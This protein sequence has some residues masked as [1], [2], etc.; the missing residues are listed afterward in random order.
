MAADQVRSGPAAGLARAT[1][2]LARATDGLARA[3]AGRGVLPV[4]GLLYLLAIVPVLAVDIV[5]LADFTNHIARI[6][7]LANIA[8]DPVLQSNY[9]LDWAI[10]PNLGIDILLP[11]LTR[12]LP[13]FVVG[14][15]FVAATLLSL[16]GGV[17]A[18]HRVLHGKVGLWPAAAFLFLYNMTLTMGFLNFL[19]GLGL[20]L[21]ALAGWIALRGRPAWWRIALFSAVAVVLFFTHLMALGAYGLL[22]GAWELSFALNPPRDWRRAVTDWSIGGAQFVA[23][24]LLLLVSL[25]PAPA[26]T[27]VQYASPLAKLFV[28]LAPVLSYQDMIDGILFLF[29][30]IV[31]AF[32]LLTRRFAVAANMG[33]PMLLLGAAAAFLPFSG[34]GRFGGFW[35]LDLRFFVILAFV[36]VAALDFRARSRSIAVIF[37]VSALVLFAVRIGEVTTDWRAY[38]A[39]F[40]EYRAAAA[41]IEPGSAVL[42]AQSRVGPIAGDRNDFAHTYDYMATL[43]IIDRGI[44]LPNF[45]TDPV[46]QPVL[47]APRRAAIDTPAG[48]PV[49]LAGLRALAD[50]SVHDWYRDDNGI[51]GERLYGYMWQDNFDYVVVVH[52][53]SQGNPAPELLAPAASG[54]FFDIYRVIGGGCT[55]DYPRACGR[56]RR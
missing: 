33:L 42:Q 2:G 9:R 13:L 36:A 45:F 6:H 34:Y 30:V 38:D 41:I 21:C 11:P 48:T 44:F 28:I 27:Y 10:K 22:V 40:A 31:I 49:T 52:D 5:P 55:E 43:S 35:G 56:L 53:G 19:L 3:L 47:P 54:S 1:E 16:V 18:L 15:L 26:E 7:L 50:P 24:A 29:V 4:Y 12:I 51:V 32:A 14:K 8:G 17:A 46:K 37:G 20:C 23:P 25:P 39:Q